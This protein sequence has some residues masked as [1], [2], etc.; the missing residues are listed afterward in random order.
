MSRIGLACAV[1]LGLLGPVGRSS[2]AATISQNFD[3]DSAPWVG[4][5]NMDAPLSF[6]LSATDN[7][8]GVLVNRHG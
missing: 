8:G 7:A 1:L 6:G 2:V 4:S 5:G 3:S